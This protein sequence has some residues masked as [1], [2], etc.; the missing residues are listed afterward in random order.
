MME[1]P[2]WSPHY[3]YQKKLLESVQHRFLKFLA[4]KT[5][6]QIPNHDYK[7]IEKTHNIIN[8]E[9]RRQIYDLTFLHKIINNEIHSSDLLS[10]IHIKIPSRQTR[11][12]ATFELKKHRNNLGEYATLHRCQKLWN[13]ASVR[14]VDV[15]AN[16][17]SNILNLLD[18]ENFPFTI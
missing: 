11:N 2:V 14:G 18:C 5:K 17:T 10:D 9:A 1:Y 8:L 3:E 13:L 4:F 6:Q 12:K 16:N 7:A 15:F